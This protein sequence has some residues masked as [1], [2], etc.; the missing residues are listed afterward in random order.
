MSLMS[1][2]LLPEVRPFAI[3]AAMIVVVG[4]VELV[5]MLVGFSISEVVGKTLD[6]DG[7]A[8]SGWINAISWLHIRGVPLLVYL[9][10]ALAFFSMAGFVIQDAARAIAAPLPAWISVPA[11]IVV[12]LPLVR[13]S[14]AKVATLV[15]RDE[16]Y[17]VDLASL[18]GRVGH[19]AIGPLDQGPPGRVRVEDKYGNLHVVTA[20]AALD[21]PPIPQGTAVLL[22]DLVNLHFTAVVAPDETTARTRGS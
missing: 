7:H 5:S 21:S 10:I 3:A 13:W 1:H 20:S 4:A 14:S 18:V 11:A 19:V 22:V 16:S 15:P 12:A 9:M 8:D 2:L 6:F 17:A